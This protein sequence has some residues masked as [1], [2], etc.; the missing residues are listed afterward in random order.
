[1]IAQVSRDLLCIHHMSFNPQCDSLDALQQQKSADRRKD[2]A[3]YS[4]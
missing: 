1:M 4:L 3:G 2:S